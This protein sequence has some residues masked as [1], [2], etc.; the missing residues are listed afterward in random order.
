[1]K[2]NERYGISSNRV[3]TFTESYH[4]LA[5]KGG[6]LEV[7]NCASCHGVHNIKPSW[8]STSSIHKS[9]LI[10]TCGKCHPGANENFTK[11]KM[12]VDI[13]EKEEPI[14]YTISTLYIILIITL[15]GGMFLHNLLDLIKKA[16]VK[17]LIRRGAIRK[18]FH[19][20]HRLYLR[21]TKSERIQHFSL[22]VSFFT[23]VL[24]GFMLSYPD[25]WWTIQIRKLF[26]FSYDL[27]GIIHRIAAIVLIAASLYHVYYLAF[28]SR[29]RQLFVDLLPRLKD[30]SDAVGVLK[31]NLGFSKKK[32]KFERF[33]YIEKS[34]YWALV[35]GNIVMGFTGFIMWFENTFIGI[36]TKLGWDIARTVHYY[37]AWLAFLA[38]L[39]WHI[40]FVIF[41]PDVY[42]MNLA[43]I[44]GTLT[45]EEMEEEHPLE[46]EKIKQQSE[47][48]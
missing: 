13:N 48:Q 22:L 47:E 35:W 37:E 1:V 15:I 7:A 28:T 34:E 30:L 14:L 44:K 12:H 9:N 23:L 21:M 17:F 2:L 31:Y 27:R 24:T 5:L 6:S 32:P 4:G 3:S 18:E 46:L 43:W 33:S 16:K 26:P 25:A 38:I 19:P 11:G 36:F 45:E 8:D 41:N 10:K 39:V 20:S 40:Y 29:G 42:P